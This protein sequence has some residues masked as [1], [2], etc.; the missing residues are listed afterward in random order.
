MLGH[1]SPPYLGHPIPTSFEKH[2]PRKTG[3]SCVP[4]KMSVGGG[5]SIISDFFI[6]ESVSENSVAIAMKL[7]TQ[8]SN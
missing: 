4:E 6:F 2:Q 5:G 8:L 1:P 7:P 3:D